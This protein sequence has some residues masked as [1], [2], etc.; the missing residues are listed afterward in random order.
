MIIAA[1]YD[2]RAYRLGKPGVHFY[3]I[4]LPH[5]SQK[6]QE[7]VKQHMPADKVSTYINL[8]VSLQLSAGRYTA[9]SPSTTVLHTAARG[10]GT[11]SAAD[12]LLSVL[13][14]AN[15]VWIVSYK[16]LTMSAL[17]LAVHL[18]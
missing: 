1:G 7:L 2:T 5:A 8:P 11:C 3:E 14:A 17:C 13:Q 12:R 16:L 9:D 6:K 10:M 18:A 4:D 15:H